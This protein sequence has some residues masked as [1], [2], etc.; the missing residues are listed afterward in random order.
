MEYHIYCV[1][2]RHRSRKRRPFS[3]Y[4]ARHR[5]HSVYRDKSFTSGFT[6]NQADASAL[7]EKLEAVG[8]LKT[9]LRGRAGKVLRG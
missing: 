4:A 8:D 3:R 5:T 2:F 6:G 9:Q 7:E 1:I